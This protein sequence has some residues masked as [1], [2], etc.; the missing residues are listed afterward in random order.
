MFCISFL[1]FRTSVV[2][3]LSAIHKKVLDDCNQI[4]WAN[5]KLYD[6]GDFDY[7]KTYYTLLK[8]LMNQSSMKRDGMYGVYIGPRTYKQFVQCFK[9][10][11]QV[12]ISEV[13]KKL[14]QRKLVCMPFLAGH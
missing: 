1:P 7:P 8:Q 13:K 5:Q 11:Y 3:S 6:M 2:T 9:H 10:I 4:P 14:N 12:R